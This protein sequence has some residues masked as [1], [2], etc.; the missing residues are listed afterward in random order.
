MLVLGV[1]RSP[2]ESNGLGEAARF[3]VLFH[4]LLRKRPSACGDA[5]PDT[6]ESD[7]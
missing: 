4:P 5:A 6:Q 1:C 3:R 2:Y 7:G